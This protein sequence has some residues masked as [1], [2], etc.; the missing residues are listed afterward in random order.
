MRYRLLLLFTSFLFYRFGYSQDLAPNNASLVDTNQIYSGNQDT[1]STNTPRMPVFSGSASETSSEMDVQDISGILQSSRDIFTST[2]SYHFSLARF[3]M[4]G[5]DPE[6]ST[7]MMNGIKLNDVETGWA[8][9]SSWG[10]L[11]DVTRYMDIRVGISSSRI[12][13]GG[14]GINTN[15]N[16]RAS[17][18]RKGHKLSYS[19]SNRTYNH[20]IMY[21]ASTG[22]MKNGWTFSTSVSYRYANESYIEGTN[23]SGLSYFFSVEKKINNNHVLNA[24]ILGAPTV[25]ARQGISTQESND[26]VG[27]NYYN[28]FW[29]YQQGKKRS[30]RV[31]N[32]HTP[33]FII[34]HNW[35]VNKKSELQTSV[36]LNYG[37]RGLTALNWNDTD[38][39][40][41]D[42]YRYLPSYYSQTN[43]SASQALSNLWQNDVNTRQINWDE[44]YNANYNNLHAVINANGIQGNTITGL[45]SKYIL[46]EQR[47]DIKQVNWNSIYRNNLTDK[48]HLTVGYT[49]SI[50]QGLYFKTLNDLL[51]GDYWVDVDQFAEQLSTDGSATQND[52][53]TP[54][55]IIRKGDKFGYN[56]TIHVN[57]HEAF[58]QIE[59]NLR[60]FEFYGGVQLSQTSFWRSSNWANGKFP[61]NSAGDSEKQN[62]F[63]YGAKFGTT[64]KINGRNYLVFNGMYLT[65]PPQVSYSF[66][67]PRTRNDI[68]S[69]ITNEEVKSADVNYIKRRPNLK[70]R[71]TL[72]YTE[73]NNQLWN[74]S[75]YHEVYRGLVNYTMNNVDFLH[76]GIEYGVEANVF[77]NVSLIGVFATGQHVFNSRPQATISLD[78][79]SQLLGTRTVYLKNYKI[80]NMPQTAAS[81]GLKYSGKRYWFAGVNYNYYTDIYVEPN[82]DRRTEETLSNFVVSDPQ[83]SSSLDQEKLNDAYTIDLFAGKSWKIKKY[84]INLNFSVNNLLNNRSFITGGTEQLRFDSS[85][86]NKFPTKYSY[87]L[88]ATYFVMLSF[89]YQ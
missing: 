41:P 63:N 36:A 57:H 54:N 61:N 51:G 9:W 53:S 35:F 42:Y 66:V 81:I 23:F 75:Y 64:Y 28:P 34:T 32:T 12:N 16:A 44:L 56:Y 45:R 33:V 4:R 88:G 31:A 8:S 10:G 1:D 26:L 67:S 40:R 72:Y 85:N 20:R 86:I 79:S 5:Y 80:G 77:Q 15:I 11:N 14:V 21:T 68:I 84:F 46:E 24:S 17:S 55:K 50:H 82:P 76:Y 73:L 59:Y 25:Q 71:L 83:W 30:S 2:A 43:P 6:N 48:L 47:N 69:G 62:F 27:S 13:F 89:R 29:G 19:M 39:P 18:I 3:R 22:M 49:G 65:R 58:S 78:N 60:K 37:R 7:V 74:R 70:S 38:D 52:I 87:H